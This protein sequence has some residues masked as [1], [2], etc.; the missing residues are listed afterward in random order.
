MDREQILKN[1]QFRKE[2]GGGS[3][4]PRVN[5]FI[6]MKKGKEEKK[7]QKLKLS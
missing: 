1:V 2:S 6:M 4:T 3:R 7:C 5:I